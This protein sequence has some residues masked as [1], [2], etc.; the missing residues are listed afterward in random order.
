MGAFSSQ[1]PRQIFT[2]KNIELQSLGQKCWL[3]NQTLELVPPEFATRPD[4]SGGNENRCRNAVTSEQRPRLGEIVRVSIV[5]S[6]GYG[7]LRQRFLFDASDKFFQRHRTAFAFDN[8]EMLGKMLR[9]HGQ[10]LRIGL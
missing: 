5:K 6:N 8:F 7:M 1:F 3:K 4:I 10:Q 2:V 9:L